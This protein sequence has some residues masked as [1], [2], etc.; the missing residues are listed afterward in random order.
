M[1]QPL[2]APPRPAQR[3]RSATRTVAVGVLTLVAVTS[4]SLAEVAT[5]PGAVPPLQ[6][7]AA[8]VTTTVAATP[9]VTEQPDRHA[10]ALAA[11]RQKS[12]V[13]ITGE[14]T[15]SSLT[16]ANPDGSFTTEINPSPVRVQQGGD[17]H[18]I[19]TT[20]IERDGVLVPKMAKGEVEISAGG[21]GAPMAKL[22]HAGDESFA[23]SWPTKLPEP[24]VEGNKATYVNAAGPDAD[25]VV[26]ALPT[27]FR[28]DVVLRKRPAGPVE[29]KLEVDTDGLKLAETK[30][31]SLT[32]TDEE[33]KTVASAPQPVMYE[34]AAEQA[35]TAAEA[36][37]PSEID[38]RVVTENGQQLLVLKPDAE[39]LAD[40]DTQY[41]VVVD[42]TTTL[43]V[44][45]DGFVRTHIA[46]MA[47][48]DYLKVG[49]SDG[50]D[51]KQRSLIKF[52][53]AS[54]VGKHV[55]AAEMRLWTSDIW[56]SSQTGPGVL[57]RRL[58][59]NWSTATTH[60]GNQPTFTNT[61]AVTV[62]S[63]Y[64]STWMKFP[65]TAITQAWAAG[66]PNYGVHVMGASETDIR[67]ARWFHSGNSGSVNPP[68]L[69]VTYNSYPAT[70]TV[71]TVGVATGTDGVAYSTATPSLYGAAKDADGGVSRIYFEVSSTAGTVLWTSHVSGLV[72]GTQGAVTVPAGI[73][74]HGQKWRWRARGFDGVDYGP[75][76]GYLTYT[77]DSVKP[78]P[79]ES[80]G[81][82][83]W[84]I[85]RG[86]VADN[87]QINPG[88][89]EAI[90][91]A[92]QARTP[93]DNLAAVSVNL[94]A[95][96]STAAGSLGVFA[97]DD[98]ASDATAISYGTAMDAQNE[99]MSK[100]GADGKIKI[101]NK[102]SGPVNVS[103]DVHGY[104]VT[105][106]G[107]PTYAAPT[108]YVPIA[109]S[110]IATDIVVPAS[111]NYE[112][113]PMGKGD[114]PASNVQA[115]AI[116][117]SGKSEGSGRVHVYASDKPLPADATLS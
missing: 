30:S 95:Q 87:L 4:A 49:S 35:A 56:T 19:D 26:T 107:V 92:G 27:G 6:A 42:P 13:L 79:Y 15:E 47:N 101:T 45:T 11:Q 83:Q 39:F 18:T 62:K 90:Q 59:A 52:N 68:A 113:E 60:W 73:L 67:S 81:A 93:G 54:L 10:A 37:A 117:I 34:A 91:I 106:A 116:S 14:T 64:K 111:G 89:T 58:L 2:P 9:P 38:T 103:V 12:R 44:Y 108:T 36:A 65:I 102:G 25:L 69:V 85:D 63:A 55:T 72:A 110:Q 114:I 86:R 71:K 23:L 31:G 21:D 80:T 3:R 22:E 24:T 33:G 53:V 51:T 50:G 104:S 8:T 1:G 94:T 82:G 78:Q 48:G 112:L 20:L 109:A 57:V 40:P 88:A 99:V 77:V 97:S 7:A 16:Y 41:P 70:A 115:A 61:G 100:V 28:H 74:A 46:D 66:S 96:G 29:Y 98:T 75:W 84:F 5:L 105:R 76:S 32:L 43:G 17:W